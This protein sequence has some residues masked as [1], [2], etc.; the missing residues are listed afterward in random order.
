L[1]GLLAS[2]VLATS[3]PASPYVR[4]EVLVGYSASTA[5]IRLKPGESVSAAIAQLRQRPGV[6]WAVP[7]Y[8]A[9][10]SGAIIPNDPGSGGVPSGWEALQW[11]FAGLFGVD[12]PE[13][14]FNSATEGA[15]GGRGVVVAVLDTGIAYANHGPFHRSPDFHASTFVRGYDFIARNSHPYDRN[16]HGTFVAGTIAEATNN[17]FGLTGLAWGARIMPVRVLDDAGEGDASVIAEGIRFAVRH[18]AQIINL[19]LEFSSDVH[20][21]DIPEL[22]AALRYARH[23]RVIVVAAAGNEDS[24]RI[25]YPAR[26]PGVIAVGASTEHGCLA[27][28]SN[29]G[30]GIALV[31]PGGGPDANLPGDPNCHTELP[32][33][34]DIFQ[35]TFTGSS[36]ARFGFPP[37]Y[38]GT[39]MAAP[40][41]S[42]T[43]ALILAGGIL[44]HRPTVAQI[45]TRLK[46]TARPLGG[47][48]D[49]RAYGAGLLDAAAATAPGGPVALRG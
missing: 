33:G 36:P 22:I 31:A 4:N 43:A 39:S 21:S 34:R 47:A 27:A 30:T 49:R 45:T 13:A 24:T 17:G 9:H 40:H 5:R 37:G 32:S 18:H 41:V 25:P 46:A 1:L 10:A 15:P 42:A 11:N 12:A 8:I 6:L 26:G 3:A 23:H 28:Y 35:M 20:S 44:G 29:H 2:L 14:W 38:E 16:G 48:Q 7:D 19:S